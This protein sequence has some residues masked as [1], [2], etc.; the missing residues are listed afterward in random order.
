L[1]QQVSKGHRWQKGQSGNPAGRSIG[2]RQK[3]SERLLADL[4]SVWEKHGESVLER[5]A[6]TEPGKLATIA[7]GLLPRDVF[8]SVAP[9]TPGN[10]APE[11]WAVMVDLVRLIKAS[12]PTDAQALPSDLAP[13]LEDAVRAHFAKP[14]DGT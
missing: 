1:N 2:A 6:V 8:I 14:V 10:L 3:I 9:S 4:A 11:E 5:L 12:A 7:Y 13:A